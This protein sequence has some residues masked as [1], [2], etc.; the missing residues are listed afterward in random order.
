MFSYFSYYKQYIYLPAVLLSIN[1]KLFINQ[2]SQYPPLI[3][4][5]NSKNK[6]NPFEFAS[7]PLYLYWQQY[8]YKYTEKQLGYIFQCVVKVY[9]PSNEEFILSYPSDKVFR[10]THHN[11]LSPSTSQLNF[12]KLFIPH[13]DECYFVSF[14]YSQ[15]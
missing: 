11:I 1:D 2:P 6:V 13:S 3:P 15:V 5:S 7:K 12:R 10:C 8:N 14:D 9:T 4:K